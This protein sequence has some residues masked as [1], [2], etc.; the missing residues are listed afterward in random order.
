[1]FEWPLQTPS[2]ITHTRDSI[3]HDHLCENLKKKLLNLSPFVS[4]PIWHC[5]S[6]KRHMSL[7]H[8]TSCHS[9]YDCLMA[10]HFSPPRLQALSFTLMKKADNYRRVFPP[11]QALFL[12]KSLY[13]MSNLRKSLWKNHL[14]VELKWMQWEVYCNHRPSRAVLMKRLRDQKI[15]HGWIPESPV[16]PFEQVSADLSGIRRRKVFCIV[17]ELKWYFSERKRALNY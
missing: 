15:W 17:C 11:P 7:F 16:S 6:E 14:L 5:S 2:I 13:S 4:V 10:P 12:F 9:D 8:Q 1:V 3:P